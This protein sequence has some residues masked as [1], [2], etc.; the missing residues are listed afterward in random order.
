MQVLWVRLRTSRHTW[1]RDPLPQELQMTTYYTPS[2]NFVT[3]PATGAHKNASFDEHA[4]QRGRPHRD[5][6]HSCRCRPGN[7][8]NVP[9]AAAASAAVILALHHR[10]RSRTGHRPRASQIRPRWRCQSFI[11]P[12][13][14]SLASPC[15]AVGPPCERDGFWKP[16]CRADRNPMQFSRGVH[17]DSGGQAGRVYG[18]RG[19]GGG[20][21]SATASSSTR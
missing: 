21:Q 4:I 18:S 17:A 19:P 1:A 20:L 8:R 6:R 11:Q 13:A 9:A 16:C 10:N 5:A 3:Q 2:S 12:T 14:L 7:G 15:V